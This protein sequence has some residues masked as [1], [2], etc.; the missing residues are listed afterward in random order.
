GSA[1]EEVRQLSVDRPADRGREDVRRKRPRVD[2]VAA[3][4]G[5]DPRERGPDD[6]LIERREEQSKEDRGDD[7]RTGP[8]IHANGHS[9]SDGLRRSG[10]TPIKWGLVIEQHQGPKDSFPRMQCV[11]PNGTG[12]LRCPHALP[13]RLLRANVACGERDL[14]FDLADLL[15]DHER[16]MAGVEAVL[17]Q[18]LAELHEALAVDVNASRRE[19]GIDLCKEQVHWYI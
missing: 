3:K 17:L 19:T 9:G 1:T 13:D 16:A 11:F 12:G 18:L 6:G 7:L 5:H 10:R 4:V 8:R 14:H 15:V 2:V